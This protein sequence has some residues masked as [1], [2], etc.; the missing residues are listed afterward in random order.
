M[1]E[2]ENS[3]NDNF[4]TLSPLY[5]LRKENTETEKYI[6]NFIE[7]NKS[8]K[9][10]KIEKNKCIDKLKE[11]ILNLDKEKNELNEKIKNIENKLNSF[12]DEETKKMIF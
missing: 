7:E 4:D 9:K 5:I 3:Y 2:I 11:D 12:I 1:N 10:E 6:N 8:I